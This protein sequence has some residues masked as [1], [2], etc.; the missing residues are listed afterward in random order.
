MKGQ[1]RNGEVW[2]FNKDF[3]DRELQVFWRWDG[4]IR[5]GG[6]ETATQ[7]WKESVLENVCL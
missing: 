1:L 6:L 3:K 4:C 2:L 7:I 5:V